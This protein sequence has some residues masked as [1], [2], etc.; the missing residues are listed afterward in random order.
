MKKLNLILAV[1]LVLLQCT[2]HTRKHSGEPIIPVT[3]ERVLLSPIISEA[4]LEQF[5]GWPQ[6]P[7]SQKVLLKQITQIWSRLHAEFLHKEKLGQYTMV[8]EAGGPS[9]RISIKLLPYEYS[10]DT[11]RMPV[12][13]QAHFLPDGKNFIYTIPAA[14]S[15]GTADSGGRT[16]FHN[17]GLLLADYRR[18]FPYKAIVSFYYPH[19]EETVTIEK[20]QD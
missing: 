14:G 12:R 4:D 16:S 17:I 19:E 18:N 9:V 6:D 2:S 11:F 8:S 3:Y 20:K 5:P 10:Q 1:A 7:K 13:M 15:I